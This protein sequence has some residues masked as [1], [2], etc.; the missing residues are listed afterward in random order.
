MRIKKSIVIAGT[1]ATLGLASVGGI[2]AA[3]TGSSS[4][5]TTS[6]VDKIATKFNLNKDD[7]QKVFDTDRT[8]HQTEREQRYEDRLTQA[9]KDGKL[10]EAQKVKIESKHKELQAEMDKNR[11]SMEADR[12]AMDGKTD[13]ERQADREQ[14]HTEMAAQRTALQEWETDNGIPAGYL[15]FGGRGR[16]PGGG[17]GPR[18]F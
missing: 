15:G 6:L 8:E 17:H 1:A 4:A 11:A 7:V 10:T 16:G 13:A 18:G 12:A 2:A 3:A 14:R 9:V 5:S